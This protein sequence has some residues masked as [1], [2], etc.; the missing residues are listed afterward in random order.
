MLSALLLPVTTVSAADQ[1]WIAG[2][3]TEGY[4]PATNLQGVTVSVVGKTTTATTDIDG[5]YNLSIAVGTYDLKFT[6]LNYKD[7][8]KTAIVVAK[9]ATKTVNVMMSKATG[10]IK[11]KVTDKTTSKGIYMA[12]VTYGTG[13]LA[14]AFTES[15]GSYEIK[16]L[17]VG[18]YT[19]NVTTIG[20]E[21]LS[22]K[23]TVTVT[24]NTNTTKDFQL[25][26]APV[27]LI[28]K[29]Y[30]DAMQTKPMSGATIT[31]GTKTL[32]TDSTGVVNFTGLERKSYS[33]IVTAK[34][35]K[36]YTTSVDLSTGSKEMSLMPISNAEI[37]GLM[38]FVGIML[39]LVCILPIII[40]VIIVVVI[41]W[42]LMRR[43][44]KKQQAQLQPA[45]V[46]PGGVP[47]PAA[48]PQ[49]PTY[50][51]MYGS[52]APQQQP[53]YSQPPAPPGQY[54]AGYTPPP[55][56]PGQYQQP[57]PQY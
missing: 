24:A 22:T 14:Y 54:G 50:Q 4:Y 27:Y 18:S 20:D 6:K 39:F 7:Y 8:S 17:E 51:Q 9:N 19:L 16:N 42:L 5:K 35:Y 56:P 10:G 32:T 48:P 49:Q 1:G 43:K 37:S 25:T 11:G 26:Q 30:K 34:G 36:K 29:V 23:A 33:V 28:V 15:D 12:Q 52:P 41:I 2:T 53:G 44:K 40:I 31:V 13:F 3:V 21:Y 38:G 57:P 55:S 45:G 47:P 46:P